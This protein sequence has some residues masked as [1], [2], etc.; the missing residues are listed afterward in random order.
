MRSHLDLQLAGQSGW[1]GYVSDD[2][3]A[4]NCVPIVN[5][6]NTQV[7]QRWAFVRWVWGVG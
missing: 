4:Q 5:Y 2:T 6:N 3:Q 7:M 1:Q